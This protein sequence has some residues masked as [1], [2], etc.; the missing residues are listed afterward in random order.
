M[1][2]ARAT[3]DS[4]LLVDL[5]ASC[6]D[7]DQWRSTVEEVNARKVL[8]FNSFVD[9]VLAGTTLAQRD[10]QQLEA[11]PVGSSRWMDA[12]PQPE[13][14]ALL[15]THCLHEVLSLYLHLARTVSRDTDLVLSRTA[16]AS[17][18]RE[19]EAFLISEMHTAAAN[20]SHEEMRTHNVSVYHQSHVRE[21]RVKQRETQNML[22]QDTCPRSAG[23]KCRRR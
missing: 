7:A 20:I 9:E 17:A 22:S 6:E 4:A 19:D 12:L 23:G 5:A 1:Q 11:P 10:T 8:R 3:H 16:M 15:L 21:H 18:A 14:T 2:A 13:H